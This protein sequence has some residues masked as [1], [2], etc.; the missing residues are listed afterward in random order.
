[1]KLSREGTRL[2]VSSLRELGVANC[3]IFRRILEEELA[4]GVSDL[5]IDLADTHYLDCKGLGALLGAR[6]AIAERGQPG[7]FRL[8]N[9][10]APIQRMLSV[11]QLASLWETRALRPVAVSTFDSSRESL[12]TAE[13]VK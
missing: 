6:K 11:T 5:T 4:R 3:A 9:P 1:M 10:P 8:L 2:T 13:L 12:P 7:C